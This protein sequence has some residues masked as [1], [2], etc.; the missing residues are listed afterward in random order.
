MATQVDLVLQLRALPLPAVQ[1]IAQGLVAVPGCLVSR[2]PHD[3]PDIFLR[4]SVQQRSKN[5]STPSEAVLE[6][7]QQLE[8]QAQVNCTRL[9]K[10]ISRGYASRA[11][12]RTTPPGTGGSWWNAHSVT[13]LVHSHPAW[14]S[15]TQPPAC[16]TIPQVPSD[17][18]DKVPELAS[19]LEDVA[20]SSSSSI[21]PS[22]KKLDHQQDEAP[23]GSDVQRSVTNYGRSAAA[24][25][26]AGP[27]ATPAST[28]TVAPAAVS[29]QEGAGGTQQLLP[30]LQR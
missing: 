25:S 17:L 9:L 30:M 3:G 27:Q 11:R 10:T 5:A 15:A 21:L 18:V 6:A 20:N 23:Y 24:L 2:I 12:T 26:P 22:G 7:V 4:A 14:N 16:C 1:C 13:V 19:L 28:G 8:Q 29:T